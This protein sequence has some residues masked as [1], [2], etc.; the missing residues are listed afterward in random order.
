MKR[1]EKVNKLQERIQELLDKSLVH[2]LLQIGLYKFDLK[3]TLTNGTNKSNLIGWTRLG[4][5]ILQEWP[6]V[7]ETNCWVCFRSNNLLIPI[8]SQ[9]IR[10]PF[11]WPDR[12]TPS[13]TTLPIIHFV[14]L[15]WSISYEA[16]LEDSSQPNRARRLAQ[17][18]CGW[19]G[20]P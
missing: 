1:P 20:W 14:E 2:L 8:S 12:E 15:L 6:V 11:A 10:L 5:T 7:N 17:D 3:A 4:R 18:F 9:A 19:A 16:S 13:R